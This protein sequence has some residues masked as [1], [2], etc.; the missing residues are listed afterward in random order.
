MMQK[1][2][3]LVKEIAYLREINDLLKK[4]IEE[5]KENNNYAQF[6]IEYLDIIPE[7]EIRRFLLLMD[8][9]GI[10]SKIAR[11]NNRKGKDN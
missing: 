10:S 9:F 4:Y 7:H 1:L 11:I 2:E 3:F 8:E 5:I 6:F